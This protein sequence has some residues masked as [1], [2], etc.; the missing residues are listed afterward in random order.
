MSW[1]RLALISTLFLA[2]DA[3]AAEPE[4]QDAYVCKIAYA[5]HRHVGETVVF[6]G[7]YLTDH[8]ERSLVRPIGCD[9]GIGLGSM[10]P[11]AEKLLVEADPPTWR[12]GVR[13]V[14]A[15]FKAQLVQDEPNGFEFFHDTGVRLNVL[16]I[17]ELRTI[18]TAPA[19]APR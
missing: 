18:E 5:P 14:V 1:W 3:L 17:G 7:E 16:K 4:P 10:T 9:R 19:A 6:R 12:P 15:V 13:R 8:I 11:E 2:E